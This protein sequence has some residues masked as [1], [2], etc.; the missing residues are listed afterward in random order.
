MGKLL[1]T[2]WYVLYV[3]S[4]YERKVDELLKE[5]G[6]ESFL[7]IVTT[8]RKWSDRQKKL[9]IPL[10]SSY[11]FVNIKT[12]MDFHKTLS[13][14]GACSFIRFGSEYGIVKDEEI[15]KIKF[16]VDADSVKDIKVDNESYEEG[17]VMLIQ[18]G[19]LA[20][21][22]CEVININNENKIIVRLDSINQ[23]ITATVPSN[24]LSKI[25]KAV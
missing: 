3:R 7:P 15:N 25:S 20:G 17:E 22:E 13:V 5:N 12:S 11:V 19:S 8:I 23:G 4:R 21:I 6:L 9:E 24:Y 10:F 2:G 1:K 18:Y 16:L 14:E